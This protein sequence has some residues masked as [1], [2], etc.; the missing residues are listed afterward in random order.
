MGYKI[1]IGL[2]I[3]GLIAFSGILNRVLK[4]VFYLVFLAIVGALGLFLYSKPSF[5]GQVDPLVNEVKKVA[6]KGL[7]KA[8]IS[9]GFK[10]K[11]NLGAWFNKMALKVKN[12]AKNFVFKVGGKVEDR[13][14]DLVV[15]GMFIFVPIAFGWIYLKLK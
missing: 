5:R 4:P 2:A 14:A 1:K 10:K 11:R 15:Y 13:V 12:K 6:Q 7:N 3:I 8:K 9:M